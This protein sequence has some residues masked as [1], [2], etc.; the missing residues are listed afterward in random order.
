MFL[1]AYVVLDEDP[2]KAWKHTLPHRTIQSVVVFGT[3]QECKQRK[4]KICRN[5]RK[6]LAF[7]K[8]TDRTKN[9]ELDGTDMGLCLSVDDQAAVRVGQLPC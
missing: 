2:W 1:F 4:R 6:S 3:N 9:V 8:R 7:A 5:S